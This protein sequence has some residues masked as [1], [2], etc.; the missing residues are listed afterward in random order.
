MLRRDALWEVR[1]SELRRHHALPLPA[2]AKTYTCKPLVKQEAVAWDHRVSF[3]STHGHPMQ[4]MR[5]ELTAMRIPTAQ[6]VLGW[7]AQAG[8][9]FVGMVI[10]RQRPQTASGVSFFTLEDETGMVNVVIWTQV[11][12]QHAVLAKTATVLGITGT[13]QREAG[14]VHLI[15]R[16][17]WAFAPK[18]DISRLCAVVIF[19]SPKYPKTIVAPSIRSSFVPAPAHC[20]PHCC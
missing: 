7:P 4:Q 11:F 20:R 2:A 8:C 14:V 17:L 15:A 13:I 5:A 9:H 19:N 12:E 6:A 18:A 10:C 1:A 16:R 3:H